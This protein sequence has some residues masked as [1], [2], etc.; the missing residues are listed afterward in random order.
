[1]NTILK[2]EKKKL[3]L[4]MLVLNKHDLNNNNCRDYNDLFVF[5]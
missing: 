2:L 4:T 1:M 5:N 3:K